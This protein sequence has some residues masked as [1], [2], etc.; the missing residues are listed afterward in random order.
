LL[1]FYNFRN[2]ASKPSAIG[3]EKNVFLFFLSLISC[4]SS[5]VRFAAK[6]F[7][8]LLSGLLRT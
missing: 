2:T 8:E 3:P 4:R 6:A 1:R 7:C 5:F